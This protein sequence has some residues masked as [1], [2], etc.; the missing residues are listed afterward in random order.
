MTDWLDWL[1]QL[2]WRE[3]KLVAEEAAGV[4]KDALHVL[5]GFFAHI[6]VAALL[7]CG[8]VSPWPWAVVLAGALLNEYYDLVTEGYWH[9]PMWPGSLKDVGL[10]M[11]IPTVLLA[12][13]RWAPRLLVRGK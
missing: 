9:K 3:F 5:V 4:S 1:A 11:L 8:L 2:N 13:A 10:T 6:V 7:R 12:A